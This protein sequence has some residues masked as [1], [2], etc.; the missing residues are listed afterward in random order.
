MEA[1]KKVVKYAAGRMA[2]VWKYK[3]QEEA[4]GV[5]VRTDSDWGGNRWNRKSTSGGEIT[6]GGGTALKPG[7]RSRK[8]LHWAVP[9]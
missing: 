3:Y 2:V 4:E 1:I 6:M 7:A 9:R 5:K 8:R